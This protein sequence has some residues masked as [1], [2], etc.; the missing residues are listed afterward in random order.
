M[1]TLWFAPGVRL[2]KMVY[3]PDN[4]KVTEA[5]LLRFEIT[6]PSSDYMPLALGNKWTFRWSNDYRDYDVIE[7]VR[8][9]G[10]GEVVKMS[11]QNG[12]TSGSD[13][14]ALNRDL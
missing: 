10:P 5:E 12:Q 6:E 2:V 14:E 4:G 13:W 8:I 7:S 1:L 3:A 9:P 11:V